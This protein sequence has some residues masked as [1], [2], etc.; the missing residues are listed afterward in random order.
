MTSL[1]RCVYTKIGKHTSHVILIVVCK[2]TGQSVRQSRT[3]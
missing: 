3:M 2:N 1:V